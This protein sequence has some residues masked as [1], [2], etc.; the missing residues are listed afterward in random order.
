M[1]LKTINKRFSENIKQKLSLDRDF[2]KNILP[3][4]LPGPQEL[5]CKSN[6]DFTL[7]GGAAGGGKTMGCLI[8]AAHPARL[9]F[10]R[11]SSVFFRRT[12]PQIKNE[13]G[14]W[15]ESSQIYPLIKGTPLEARLEW[16]FPSGAS[17]RFAHL[18]HEKDRFQ[19]Q[20]AQLARLYFD[21]ITH[22]S[23]NQVFYLIGR[24]RTTIDIKPQIR[25]TCN[26]DADSWVKKL[27]DW[28]LDVEGYPIPERSGKIRWFIRYKNEF[29]WADTP[30]V[31]ESKFKNIP[32]K[33]FSFIAANIKD[34]T[35][36]M[37]K[38]PAY[39]ANLHAQNEVDRQ[40]LLF[41]NWKIRYEAG[42]IFNR[43]WLTIIEANNLPG[44]MVRFWDLAASV[45]KTA[46]FTA[47]VLM[48]K[49][50]DKFYIMDAIARQ[51]SPAEIDG[52][53]LE[54]AKRD[55]PSVAIRWE[56]EGGSAGK[57]DAAYIK[58]AL[59]GFNALPIKP[60][61]DKITRA[62][63]VATIAF[64][65][66]FFICKGDWNEMYISALH[67]F[68]GSPKILTNDLTDA[69]SGAFAYLNISNAKI[70]FSFD[71]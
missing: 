6:A 43:D 45:K 50:G 21:E 13:G 14:L 65:G 55:G 52:L 51:G 58:N 12:Y 30:E 5:F 38:D 49:V 66:N 56:E 28:Y 1:N 7:Y 17:I 46:C 40:R 48:K 2:S 18:Q 41:G 4:P 11:Y 33:S 53:M 54:T 61:G 59:K 32:P 22:F 47:G 29:I 26:P 67:D 9:S 69:T 10:S 57:R 42:T 24:C 15:D 19:W 71:K 31:L 44:R 39:L 63:P 25:A 68:D 35:I 60:Q 37:E 3:S 16:K 64:Q 27:V 23:E 20:G 8:D 70:L 34:N 36:L 62:K